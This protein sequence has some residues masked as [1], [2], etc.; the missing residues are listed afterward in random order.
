MLIFAAIRKLGEEY[1]GVE[2]LRW[3][4]IARAKSIPHCLHEALL[5]WRSMTPNVPLCATPLPWVK[6]AC[7]MG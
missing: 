7:F 5:K 6:S 3:P 2:P 1:R 4:W